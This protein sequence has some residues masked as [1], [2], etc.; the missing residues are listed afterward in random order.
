MKYRLLILFI[1]LYLVSCTNQAQEEKDK[2]LIALMQKDNEHLRQKIEDLGLTFVWQD[3]SDSL[4][5]MKWDT[6]AIR[7]KEIADSFLSRFQNI[8]N[9]KS[10]NDWNESM[11]KFRLELQNMIPLD[12]IRY[13]T[14]KRE[15]RIGYKVAVIDSIS[16]NNISSKPGSKLN[17]VIFENYI[18]LTED[19]IY[20]ICLNEIERQPRIL[21]RLRI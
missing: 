9:K 5:V 10:Q 13:P 21:Y 1:S 17:Q 16:W 14:G 3:E 15:T 6:L 11:K 7:A 19:D 4:K 20:S 18:L 12:T 8:N 2:I